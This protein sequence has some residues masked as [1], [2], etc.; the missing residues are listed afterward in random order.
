MLLKMIVS[1]EVT[2]FVSFSFCLKN[3]KGFR[4]FINKMYIFLKTS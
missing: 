4:G 2:A 3:Y 1:G